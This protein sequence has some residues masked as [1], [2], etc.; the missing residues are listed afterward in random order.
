ME[1]KNMQ[2]R[3]EDTMGVYMYDSRTLNNQV[4]L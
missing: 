1:T 3:D 2:T 4:N